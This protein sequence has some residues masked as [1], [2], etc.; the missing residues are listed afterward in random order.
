VQ[1]GAHDLS[2]LG[3]IVDDREPERARLA[4]IKPCAQLSPAR[5]RAER[6]RDRQAGGG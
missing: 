5:G 4:V 6:R 3:A 1:A 2:V